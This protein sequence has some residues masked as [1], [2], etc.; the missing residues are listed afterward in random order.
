MNVNPIVSEIVSGALRALEEEIEDFLSRVWRSPAL[1][2]SRDFSVTLTDRFGRAVTGRTLGASPGPVLE[3]FPPEKMAPGEVFLFNDPYLSPPGFGEAAELC[4]ARPL[5]DGDQIVAFLQIRARHDDLGSARPGGETTQAL[6]VFHEGILIPPVRIAQNGALSEDVLTVLARNSRLPDTLADDISAQLGALRIG[7]LRLRELVGRYGGDNLTACFA[8]LLRESEVA[9]QKE[10]IA[11]IPEGRRWE[12]EST[13]ETD[14]ISGPH[15]LRLALS[16]EGERLRVDLTGAGPQAKGPINCPL[17]GE[18]RLY[19][20]RLIA[21]LLLQL[22]ET[23][24]RRSGIALNDGVCRTIEIMLP[25]PGTILTPHFPAPTGL[26]A[27]T[28][29][30]LLSAFEK[31]LFEATSG[32]VPAGFDNF[33]T[34]SLRGRR[35]GSGYLFFRESLGAGLGAGP[36]GDGTSAAPPLGRSGAMPVEFAEARYPIRIEAIG[37]VPDSGGAGTFRGGLGLHYRYQLYVEG[38]IS[39]VAG[40]SAEGPFGGG[41]GTPGAPF[42][43]RL[44]PDEGA[45]HEIGGVSSEHFIQEGDILDIETPGGGGWGPP[46][47]RAP[48]AV[49]LDV[50]RG[51]VNPEMARKVY[52]VALKKEAG[53]WQLDAKGTERLRRG[54]K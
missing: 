46:S 41:G 42:R 15:V 22:A 37:L 52:R 48:E 35:R 28:L 11:R 45:F 2:D 13:I 53:G 16:R 50:Q 23:P 7:A 25:E 40:A 47:E 33:R 30:S 19:F 18:G 14:G 27:L 34:W 44:G 51:Y 6:E 17:Q 24:E 3:R 49:L 38:E 43:A 12:A 20:A 26:R 1:R 4:L 39:S 21:P 8:D 5:F 9:F 31:A 10:V 54:K 36:G 32:K 29:S